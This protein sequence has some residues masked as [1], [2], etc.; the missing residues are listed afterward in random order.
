MNKQ[1]NKFIKMMIVGEIGRRREGGRESER[2]DGLV[3]DT[4]TTLNTFNSSFI[5]LSLL[6]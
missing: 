6:I 5:N 3:T 1:Y 4:L 2:D